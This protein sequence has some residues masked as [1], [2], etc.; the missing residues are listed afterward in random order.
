MSPR[1][2]KPLRRSEPRPV[3][4]ECGQPCHPVRAAVAFRDDLSDD[5]RGV[6]CCSDHLLRAWLRGWAFG[7]YDLD[8]LPLDG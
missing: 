3:C 8:S 4:R 1:R 6:Y 7:R 2:R 5:V